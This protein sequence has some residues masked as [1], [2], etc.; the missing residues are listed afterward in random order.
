MLHIALDEGVEA[1]CVCWM[2]AHTSSSSVGTVVCSNGEPLS[3]AM[4]HANEM[5]DTL[6][7]NAA[8]TVSIGQAGRNWLQSCFE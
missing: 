6:A 1:W 8:E 5:A 7:K 3:E 2:P 4:R